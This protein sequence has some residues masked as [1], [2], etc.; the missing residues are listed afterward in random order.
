MLNGILQLT[1]ASSNWGLTNISFIGSTN[2]S[3]SFRAT[4]HG[5]SVEYVIK[6][7]YIYSAAVTRLDGSACPN[8]LKP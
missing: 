6:L 3:F 1:T 2:L 4:Q 7:L 5:S 8:C